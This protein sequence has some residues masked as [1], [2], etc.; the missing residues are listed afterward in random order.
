[1]HQNHQVCCSG[2][3]LWWT[4]DHHRSEVSAGHICTLFTLLGFLVQLSRGGQK[5]RWWFWGTS[6]VTEEFQNKFHCLVIS[7]YMMIFSLMHMWT[8]IYFYEVLQEF[9]STSWRS[10][11][12]ACKALQ[13]QDVNLHR[14]WIYKCQRSV[15]VANMQIKVQKARKSYFKISWCKVAT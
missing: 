7:E 13:G 10:M 3:D 2:V 12:T 9:I 6:A 8:R 11:L 1:M 14:L 4:E 15:V 5:E